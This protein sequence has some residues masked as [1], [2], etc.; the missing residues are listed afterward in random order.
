MGLLTFAHWRETAKK[1]IAK[2]IKAAVDWL[3]GRFANESG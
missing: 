2:T 1:L 3:S